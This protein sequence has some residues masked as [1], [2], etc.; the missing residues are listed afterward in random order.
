MMNKTFMEESDK[1][2]VE[3]IDNILIYSEIDEGHE[4]YFRELL[5]ANAELVVY[6]VWEVWILVLK[7]LVCADHNGIFNGPIQDWSSQ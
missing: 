6:Q 3:F 4:K 2:D 7:S 5:E 1:A